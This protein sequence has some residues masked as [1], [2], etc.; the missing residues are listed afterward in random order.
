MGLTEYIKDLGRPIAYYPNLKR[1][2]GS[3]TA[4]IL[5]CQLLYWT[6]KTKDD[7]WIWKTSDEL[8]EETGLTYNEQRTARKNL[9]GTD[10]I[11]EEYK[12]LDHFI[13]FRVNQNVLNA[14]WEDQGGKTT[15]HIEPV[16]NIKTKIEK[17]PEEETIGELY[18]R[19]KDFIDLAL[20]DKAEEANKIYEKKRQITEEIERKL[21]LTAIAEN[22]RWIKFID[23]AYARFEKYGEE[24]DVFLRWTLHNEAYNPAYWTP[25]KMKTLWSQAFIANKPQDDF[26]K[27]LPESETKEDEETAWPKEFGRKTNPF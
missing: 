9:V 12:R 4:T 11:E 1:I 17:E 26:V 6:D 24:I 10:L 25:D 22:V 21:G 3:T 14:L 18:P 8:E 13:K 2:T 16:K 19:K 23:F 5:L 20:G 15:E 27:P 7:G